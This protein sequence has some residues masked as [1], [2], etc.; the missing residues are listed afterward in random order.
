MKKIIIIILILLVFASITKPSE[1]S[2]N[3]YI[4]T[5]FKSNKNDDGLTR[6][7]KGV[8]KLQSNLTT[9]YNDKIFYSIT[10]TSIGNEKHKFI[11]IFGFWFKID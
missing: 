7:V 1:D 3:N 9:R 10:E 4:K 11:G 2:F 8:S 5:E 6:I